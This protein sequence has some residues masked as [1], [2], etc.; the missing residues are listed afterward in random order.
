MQNIKVNDKMV[1]DKLGET[2]CFEKFIQE[3][4]ALVKK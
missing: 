3:I 4:E 1:H 2:G